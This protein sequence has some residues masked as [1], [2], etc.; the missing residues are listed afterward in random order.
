MVPC[1]FIGEL[2]YTVVWGE[3]VVVQI[4]TNSSIFGGRGQMGEETGE[5][6]TD[7]NEFIYIWGSGGEGSGAEFTDFNEF[8]YIWGSGAEG[9]ET[10]E[11]FTEFNEFISIWGR[12]ERVVVQNSPILTNSSIF[13]GRGQR[14]RKV[15]T[16]PNSTNS[17]IFGGRGGGGDWC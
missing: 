15:M 9:E 5:D 17:P 3:R 12:G 11:D 13:G 8:I 2:T 6:F 1:S 7:F 10:G 14:E 4:L 16:S